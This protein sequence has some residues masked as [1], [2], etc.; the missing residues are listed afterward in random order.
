[1]RA[2]ILLAVAL[3]AMSG[4]AERAHAQSPA[5]IAPDIRISRVL[6]GKAETVTYRGQRA[7]HLVPNPDALDKDGGV[8]AFIDR[9][10]FTDG[11]ITVR[12]AGAPRAGAPPDSR[13]FVGIAFRCGAEG[14][15]L[16][17]FY[18]RPVNGRAES[19]LQRNHSAQYVSEPEYPWQR[20]RQESPGV[21][22]SYVD[23]ETG[24]WTDIRIEVSGTTARLFVHGATQPT[25][26]VT[27]LKH[28]L[29]SGAVALWAHVQTEAYFTGLTVRDR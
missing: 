7:V 18:L 2:R 28:G 16:E 4:A 15:R 20:L 14:E 23:L 10:P 11:T 17:M 26:V 29:G 24:A 22:E 6:N 13:G 5:S 19:Q 8:L 27:D 12:L 9:P 3:L 25:L 1:M 21:Y